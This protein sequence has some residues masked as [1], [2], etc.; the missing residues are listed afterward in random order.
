MVERLGVLRDDHGPT[1]KLTD[2]APSQGQGFFV[3]LQAERNA[4]E[5]GGPGFLVWKA[6]T[7]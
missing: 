4:A 6:C 1:A 7:G 2:Q 5:M 3:S